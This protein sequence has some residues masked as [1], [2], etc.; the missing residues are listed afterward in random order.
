MNS[1]VCYYLWGGN[2]RI[3]GFKWVEEQE[4]KEKKRTMPRKVADK[5]Q[6]LS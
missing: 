4:G 1:L 2:T 5:E 6:L 3:G